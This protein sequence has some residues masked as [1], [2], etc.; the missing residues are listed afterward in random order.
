MR[1]LYALS[2]TIAII[3][4]SF[5][6]SMDCTGEKS[7]KPSLIQRIKRSLSKKSL[8]KSNSTNQHEQFNQSVSASTDMQSDPLFITSSEENGYDR[9][10]VIIQQRGDSIR[11]RLAEEQ[12]SLVLP[13][14][15]NSLEEKEKNSLKDS[16]WVCYLGDS[17]IIEL[18]LYPNDFDG[19]KGCMDREKS[20]TLS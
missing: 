16:S 4:P 6:Y 3:A 19:I 13:I 10:L 17:K 5:S 1:K 14:K 12:N 8:S 11:V 18:F 15:F 20:E 7:K 2:I 9:L